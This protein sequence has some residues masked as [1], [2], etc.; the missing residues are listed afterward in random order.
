MLCCYRNS[1][2]ESLREKRGVVGAQ[3]PQ[4]WLG[5]AARKTN[6]KNADGLRKSGGRAQRASPPDKQVFQP[7]G[8]LLLLLV[9]LLVLLLLLVWLLVLLQLVTL[10][11]MPAWVLLA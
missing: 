7:F 10:Y 1:E 2:E 11:R 4:Q 3:E 6:V 5:P 8:W 9:W